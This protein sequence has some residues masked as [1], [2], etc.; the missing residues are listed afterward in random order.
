MDRWIADMQGTLEYGCNR[1]LHRFFSAFASELVSIRDTSWIQLSHPTWRRGGVPRRFWLP[2]ERSSVPA[3][4]FACSPDLF[5]F[6]RFFDG[7][8]ESPPGRNGDFVR[9]SAVERVDQAFRADRFPEFMV[10]RGLPVVFHALS[11]D[12]VVRTEQGAFVWCELETHEM[13]E[14]AGSFDAF[15]TAWIAHHA[16][17]DGYPFDATGRD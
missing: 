11:G 13:A 12:R 17:G 7:L 10:H 4:W 9:V 14:R 1:A 2:A 5:E 8:R 6:Y 15:L 3:P 16:V